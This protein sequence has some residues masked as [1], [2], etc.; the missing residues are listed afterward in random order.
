MAIKINFD[1]A[2]N[3]ETPTLL[4]ARRNGD[5]I[6]VI[7][8]V[9]ISVSD[10][11]ND[12]S[13]I[14]FNVYK[15]MNGKKCDIWDQI[16]NFKLVYCIEWDMWF[17]ITVELD[18]T[19]ETIKTVF[20]TQLGQ[21]ELSQIMLYDIEI[22]TEDDIARDDYKIPTVLYNPEHTEAS[23]LHRIME[24]AQ[25]YSI[26]H[27]D[28]TIANI[29]RTFSFSDT[30][31]Y[32]AFQEIAEEINCLFILHS[33][34]DSN[35]KIQRTISVY[36]LESN[37]LSCGYRGD[38]M[39]V[40]PECGSRLI[41]EGYG[42]DT[43]IFIAADE[44]ADSIQL[45]ANTEAIKNCFKLEAGDDLMTATIRNCNPNGTD[46]LW[47]ISDSMKADMSRE[48]IDKIDAYDILYDHYQNSYVFHL[49]SDALTNYNVL[50][51]KYKPYHDELEEISTPVQGY[52]ALMNAYYNTIDLSVY[53]QSALMPTAEMSDTSAI[54]EVSK[55]TVSNMSPVAVAD[56]S[57]ISVSAANNAVLAV[58]RVIVDS[59]YKV[60]VSE[61]SLSSQV[62]TGN[63][64]VT[65]YSD[66]TDTAVSSAISI[67][68]NDDY[69]Y[70]IQQKIQK[71]LKNE[72]TEDL[73]ITGLF[74]KSYSEFVAELKKYNLDSLSTFYD[75]CQGCI[76]ILIEQGVADQPTWAGQDPNLYDDLYMPYFQKLSAIEAEMQTRQS[77]VDLIEALQ[78]QIENEK[79]NV[80]SALN[81]QN[82]LGTDLWFEF[83]SFRREDKYSNDNYISDGLNNADLFEKA[84]EF[85]Q[86]ARK[87]IYK[88][89]ELQHSISSS[90]KNLLAIPK[91]SS[92]VNDFQVGNWLRIL[93]DDEI[94]K[95]RLIGYSIDFDNFENISIEFS[96]VVKAYSTVKSVKGVIAQAATMAT[97]Y[98]TVQR[99]AQQGE[100]SSSTINDWT[101]NGLNVTTTKIVSGADSQTQT[102]DEHGML[103]RK[104]DSI[105]E[106]YEDTQLKIVNSTIAITDNN[107]ETTKTAIGYFLYHDPKT[108]E[109]KSAYGI[110]G[111]TVVGK[112]IIGSSM[113][114][115]NESGSLTFDENGFAVSNGNNSV[116]IN[117]NS[118]SIFSIKN[119]SGNVLSF[120][121]DGN[122]VV[123]GDIMARSL[124]LLPDATVD[125]GHI[126]GLADVAVSGEYEDLIG[127]PELKAVA[128]SG[129][130]SDLAGAPVLADVATSGNYSDLKSKPVLARVATSGLYDDLTGVPVLSGVATSGSYH[131]L[132]D[133]PVL[134]AVAT[135]GLYTDL[136]GTPVLS[137]VA[138]SGSYEDLVEKPNIP[139]VI[140][141]VESGS[142]DAVTSSAVYH[143]ALNKNQGSDNAGKFLYVGTDGE[144]TTI[145]IDEIKILLGI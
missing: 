112:L 91:F 90:L 38:F 145:S 140:D 30:S 83:C 115:Y 52:P 135:S 61:S 131:D 104:Y 99:Q 111:E 125:S 56:I 86:V 60:V 144:I 81:F 26:I 4:L 51:R 6:G 97:S 9:A 33:N 87:E 35:G 15:Y 76:D 20:C 70:Y 41:D 17:E 5:K 29:Q 124:T 65:N 3:P 66:E 82:Y 13:E 14:T 126:T 21:A 80:Q 116:V 74:E 63:F 50:V 79:T 108:G 141:A 119:A 24:K 45:T 132:T 49:N 73:S 62:W 46:Y 53:L 128:T 101:S 103:F 93:I 12:A 113:G 138:V 92:L 130:Y 85:I 107:W 32:D 118:T 100:K 2:H 129:L 19:N 42:K 25:H 67:V 40:C 58:A 114:I 44:L 37:C 122:L 127:K 98:S 78:A 137:S 96:D 55:L 123:V 36:D 39:D 34:S 47:Y 75:S 54:I 59:R 106:Q 102:W 7:P 69:Q 22:N 109:L 71:L 89:A 77:E 94:Y 95:F 11:M 1:V 57:N 8:A 110:N 31:I 18:E 142:A 27:V 16:V 143:Y 136:T 117:P 84:N 43:T 64:V 139:T 10:A 133:K 68:L 48:L 28:S 121:S 23:L 72:D 134:A 120:D 105:N 88:S